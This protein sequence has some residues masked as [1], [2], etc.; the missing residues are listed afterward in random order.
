MKI[1]HSDPTVVTEADLHALVDGLL[2]AARVAL[3]TAW[4]REHPTDAARVAAW[5]AQRAQLQGLHRGLLDEPVPQALT[6]ALR[7][8]R[9]RMGLPTQIALAASILGI[10]L[11]GGWWLHALLPGPSV[12]TAIAARA[13]PGFV[14]EA[15]VAHAVYSPEQRH[16]V[17]VGVDQREHLMQWL[18]KRLGAKLS[19]PDLS[20]QG[21]SLVGGRLLP[22]TEGQARAQFMYEATTGERVT[23]H[24]S[25]LPSNQPAAETA[26]RF[27]SEGAAQ[28]FYW[29]DGRFGYAITGTQSKAKLAVIGEMA[30][31]QL[32]A[33][34]TAAGGR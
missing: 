32:T 34:H 7:P 33:A 1:E 27:A 12:D 25:V 17:E 30:Y 19:T 6:N 11:L 9:S 15:R 21:F 26:F 16:P 8:A 18:S 29:V 20:A 4:L 3:V 14:Q 31:Q 22:G 23:L 28:S 13:T 10:G 2:P 5:Q 24:V